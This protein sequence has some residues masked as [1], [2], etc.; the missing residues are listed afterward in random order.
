MKQRELCV[1][2]L[3]VLQQFARSKDTKIQKFT[4]LSPYPALCF[5]TVSWWQQLDVKMAAGEQGAYS[6]FCVCVCAIGCAKAS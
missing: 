1:A 6:L 5:S 3:V 4:F 2:L